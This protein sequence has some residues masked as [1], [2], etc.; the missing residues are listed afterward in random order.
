MRCPHHS[1]RLTH[2]SRIFSIQRTYVF[3]KRC[4]T[5]L[6]LSGPCCSSSAFCASGSILTNHCNERY[7]STIASE[8]SE[9]PTECKCGSIL[10]R[11][12]SAFKSSTICF[13]H[14]K[15]SMP[16]YLPAFSFIV[17][18]SFMTRTRGNSWRLP[19]S[20]SFGSCA[21]V[22]FTTPVP[23]SMS[24]YSSATIGIS[25]PTIGNVIVFPTRWA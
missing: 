14:S 3:S 5:K 7:G 16:S 11:T 21:G 24:T 8:R 20:K 13:R 4:G 10:I 2:Q 12:P 17:P 19:T 25:R 9:W 15:R 23:N 18:S 1:W 6:T 22:I